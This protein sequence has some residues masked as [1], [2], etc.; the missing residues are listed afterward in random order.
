MAR[1]AVVDYESCKPRK[2]SYEC[3]NVC[4]VNKT[5]R[6]TAIEALAELEGKPV[7]YE[8]AC[9]GCGLCVKA[10][11]FKALYIVNLPE[12]LEE[13]AVHRYGPNSFKLY[14]LPIPKDGQ[15]VGLIGRNGTGKTTAIRIL[16]GEIKPNLGR[17][18]DPPDWDE[19][20]RHFRGTELQVYFQKIASGKL[21]VAHKVQYV[22]VIPRRIR[23]TVGELLRRADERGVYRDLAKELGLD[24]VWDR[25][26]RKLSGGELQKLVVAAALSKDADVYVFDEPSSYLDVSERMRVARLIRREVRPGKYYL[27]VE[28]D[29]AVLD[30]L[31]DTVSI[32]YGEPGVYGIVSKPYGVRAGINHFLEGYLPAE[33]VRI[34]REPIQFRPPPSPSL[35]AP[36]GESTRHKLVEWS[37]I[38]VD[39]DG[40]T[41]E[42]EPGEVWTGEV[43]GIVGPNGIGKTTFIRVLAG[44]IE[45]GE[46]WVARLGEYTVSYKPQYVS[47]EMFPAGATVEDVLRAVN[48]ASLAPGSWLYVELVKKLRLDRMLDRE[49]RSL[50]GGEMQ[51][52]AI[53]AALAREAD[54]YLLDE[55]SAYLDIE[56]RLGV[57]KII[58]RLTET[59]QAA[60]FVVEH[61]LVVEDF[62]SDK[63]I[64]ILGEPSRRGHASSPLNLRE[65]MNLLLRNLGVTFRR[66]PQTYRPRVNKEG[67]YLDRMQ[68]ASGQYY[69]TST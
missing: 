13:D 61:D 16:A 9:I 1:V 4:P 47:P 28:H 34:R 56:E 65:G 35:Q 12:E 58:R 21:R 57:A 42:A 60:A 52:L 5:G 44:R 32:L 68:K 14:R 29:L 7:V 53:A 49:A 31:S 37:R 33:N 36:Q 23:G 27:V 45:P 6:G 50:S 41:L 8:D 26:V 30:Y 66:D 62:V 63:L 67:S 39:L 59:R 69:Y 51:K 24:R 43:I 48:P 11:P 17:Y 20:I 38:R 10:C 19:I 55:P 2:C 54:I 25:D 46:G 22:D 3:I 64:V 15:I 18:D 40:F